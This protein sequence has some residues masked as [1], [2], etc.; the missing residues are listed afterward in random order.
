[1]ADRQAPVLV[2][3][4]EDL[5]TADHPALSAAAATGRP[6]IPLYVLDTSSERRPLHTTG[7]STGSPLR[8]TTEVAV[9]VSDATQ[10][11]LAAADP[12]AL[13]ALLADA[14]GRPDLRESLRAEVRQGLMR[15]V[16]RG[17]GSGG[18]WPD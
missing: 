14:G 13:R 9:T 3:F 16:D 6:V 2:W 15:R 7:T 11:A 5:R 10:A 18:E 12:E 4:R 8:T 1:M 17:G